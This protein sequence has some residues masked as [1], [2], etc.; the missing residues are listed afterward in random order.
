MEKDGTKGPENG[1]TEEGFCPIH[2]GASEE[3][4]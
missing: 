3:D 4:R 1:C 2:V